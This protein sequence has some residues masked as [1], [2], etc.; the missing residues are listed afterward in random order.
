[1][2]RS[3]R[4]AG[5]ALA[6]DERRVPRRDDAG[7]RFC[8]QSLAEQGKGAFYISKQGVWNTTVLWNVGAEVAGDADVSPG[9]HGAMTRSVDLSSKTCTGSRG[10]VR[11]RF[12]WPPG[13]GGLRGGKTR[14]KDNITYWSVENVMTNVS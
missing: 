10:T 2:G 13:R 8:S 1:M 11:E 3:W 6:E 12:P 5:R 9:G 14:G 4:E 7:T